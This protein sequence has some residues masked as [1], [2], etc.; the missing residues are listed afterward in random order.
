MNRRFAGAGLM[1]RPGARGSNAAPPDGED[2]V[3]PLTI[4]G[5]KLL[6]DLD[7][8]VGI[9]ITGA[10]VSLWADQSGNDHSPIQGTD[11]ARPVVEADYLD[12]SP[13]VH[14]VS[15]DS[16]S[17]INGFSGIASGDMPSMFVICGFEDAGGDTSSGTVVE[18]SDNSDV[19]RVCNLIHVTGDVRTRYQLGATPTQSEAL[20]NDS[21]VTTPKLYETRVTADAAELLIDGV[22]VATGGAA[23]GGVLRVADDMIVGTGF[24]ALEGYI[25]RIL[26]VNPAPSAGERTALY[27]YF[28]ETYPSLGL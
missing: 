3:T 16:L 9:T 28:A 12:G 6:V 8:S 24:N 18:L 25:V 14:F 11:A 15:N 19:N 20:Y 26:I 1:R 4:L 21:A 7:A 22:S 10:G 27:E 17:L 13:A 2:P 23:A 5:V